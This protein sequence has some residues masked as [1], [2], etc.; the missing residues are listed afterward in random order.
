MTKNNL[1][2]VKSAKNQEIEN[3][4]K[5]KALEAA[6]KKEAK[7]SKVKLEDMPEITP[8]SKIPE[9]LAFAAEALALQP[10]AGGLGEAVAQQVAGEGFQLGPVALEFIAEI[11][12]GTAET[13]IGLA[14]A[15][16]RENKILDSFVNLSDYAAPSTIKRCPYYLTNQ[17]SPD[18]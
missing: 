16:R 18:L 2:I 12:G 9:R 17:Q 14:L 11:P 10:A 8:K 5:N 3:K 4:E 15:N 13:G 7:A 1:K 6:R